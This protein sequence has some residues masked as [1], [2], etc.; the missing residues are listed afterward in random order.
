MGKLLLAKKTKEN[1]C[2]A[3]FGGDGAD[4]YFGGYETYSQKIYNNNNCSDYTKILHNKYL[5]NNEELIYFKKKMK[6]KWTDS[7][8]S[9]AF[10]SNKSERIKLSMMLI[11]SMV[12]LPSVGLRGTDLM[13]MSQ[14][15]EPRSL[16]LRKDLITF[17]LNLPIK[18]KIMKK[19]I[20]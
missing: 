20:R 9:Y 11:D 1:N 4:E 12:Q 13:S 18:F 16:F 2:K 8:E 6:Q 3:I 19:K 7:K 10:I 15:I 14:S 17:A 5:N